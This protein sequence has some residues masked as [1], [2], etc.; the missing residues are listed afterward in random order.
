[1]RFSDFREDGRMVKGT[2]DT[3]K[4]KALLGIAANTLA[5]AKLLPLN[6]QTASSMLCLAYDAFRT[7]LEARAAQEGYKV[8]S[9]EAYTYYLI[10]QKEEKAAAIFDRYRKLR[11]GAQYYGK[12]ISL[13]IAQEAVKEIEETMEEMKKR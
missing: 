5:S 10:E 4:A 7:V 9:H 11:N 8:Y 1:M 6:E 3:Q 2:P 12:S 13:L